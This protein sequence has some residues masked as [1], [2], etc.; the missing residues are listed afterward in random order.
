MELQPTE[1][2]NH[3]AHTIYLKPFNELP[4][5]AKNVVNRVVDNYYGKDN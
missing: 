5:Y 1:Q 3:V 2:Q 4:D